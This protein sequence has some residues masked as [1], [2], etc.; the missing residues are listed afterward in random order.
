MS[1]PKPQYFG[2]LFQ[3]PRPPD[4]QAKWT[5]GIYV[6]GFLVHIIYM[7]VLYDDPMNFHFLVVR[8][9]SLQFC[10]R[11]KMSVKKA[12]LCLLCCLQTLS[13]CPKTS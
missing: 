5:A 2:H 3:T 1:G 10:G 13:A 11:V 7:Y 6:K 4:S 12:S 8:N 9:V